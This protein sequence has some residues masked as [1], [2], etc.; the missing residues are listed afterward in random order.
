MAKAVI[1]PE[2]LEM[3]RVKYER[4]DAS[5]P[6]LAK[7][8]GIN[9]YTLRARVARAGWSKKRQEI[10]AAV[11]MSAAQYAQQEAARL[12]E[13]AAFLTRDVISTT[14]AAMALIAQ[15]LKDAKTSKE[16]S[17][18]EL[19]DLT[20]AY[21]GMTAERRRALG[22]SDEAGEKAPVAINFTLSTGNQ[23]IAVGGN[24]VEVPTERIE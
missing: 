15:R 7:Q 24:V 13:D 4:G 17:A 2:L 21:R 16:L 11:K 5:I 10:K 3:L 6:E 9:P 1:S 22:L 19:A 14:N 18:K 12:A 20:N 23:P 8:H